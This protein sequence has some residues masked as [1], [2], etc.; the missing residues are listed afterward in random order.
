VRDFD[1]LQINFTPMVLSVAGILS[2]MREFNYTTLGV[3][4]GL[5][6][7]SYFAMRFKDGE[8]NIKYTPIE[9]FA[10]ESWT[11]EAFSKNQNPT[12]QVLAACF[13]FFQIYLNLV[14]LIEGSSISVLIFGF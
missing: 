3:T 7:D 4:L 8:D 5:L 12:L 10:R 13:I 6:F 14:N 2:L 11:Q 1:A 9:N